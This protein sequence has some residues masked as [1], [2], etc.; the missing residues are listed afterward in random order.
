MISPIPLPPSLTLFLWETHRPSSQVL[1]L[2]E[3]LTHV[4]LRLSEPHGKQLRPLDGDEVGLA[5]VGNGFGQQSLTTTRRP[6]EQ[7]AFG[8]GH[9]KL[10]ELL[11]MLHWVLE[12]TN[13]IPFSSSLVYTEP[14]L[15]KCFYYYYPFPLGSLCY[16]SA[17]INVNVRLLPVQAPAALS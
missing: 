17:S 16:S 7:H 14:T 6:I 1:Y 9:T 8:G 2:V 13:Y 11:W 4:G 15:N 3:D 12:K 5:L 10:Q